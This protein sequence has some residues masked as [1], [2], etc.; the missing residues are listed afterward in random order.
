MLWLY[1]LGVVMLLTI[2]LRRVW[3]RQKPLSEELYW[4]RVAIDQVHSGVAWVNGDGKLGALNPSFAATLGSDPGGMIGRDW[5]EVFADNERESI[6]EAHRQML[7][8]GKASFEAS[9]LR[10]DG[11]LAWLKVL[12]VAV[13]DSKTRLVGHRCIIEDRTL[14][15]ELEERV[16]QLT[17]SHSGGRDAARRAC[18]ASVRDCR[19][20]SIEHGQRAGVAEWLN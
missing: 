19:P 16:R 13:H 2:A 8:T 5:Y 9:G 14:E 1:L 3:R 4:T 11:T 7:L 6:E 12:L 18:I 15:R 17:L 20:A 10:A